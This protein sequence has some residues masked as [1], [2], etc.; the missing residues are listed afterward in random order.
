MRTLPRVLVAAAV[1]AGLALSAA[2]CADRGAA[3]A[4][5]DTV[6]FGELPEA[7]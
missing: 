4:P 3:A 1:A 6:Y 7:G 5:T 2:A